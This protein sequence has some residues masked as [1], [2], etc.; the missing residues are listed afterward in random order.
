M[1]HLA[2]KQCLESVPEVEVNRRQVY[3]SALK[4]DQSVVVSEPGW[5]K[6]PTFIVSLINSLEE[7][8][9]EGFA[10]VLKSLE[11]QMVGAIYYSSLES[12]SKHFIRLIFVTG[13]PIRLH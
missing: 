13:R 10:Q 2:L 9:G 3:M 1:L 7:V 4:E 11:A 5:V 8:K 6:S 12:L